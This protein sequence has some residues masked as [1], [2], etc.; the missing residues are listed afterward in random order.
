[1][2][3]DQ[4]LGGTDGLG[5]VEVAENEPVF[6]EEWEKAA[7]GMFSMAFRAGFFDVDSFLRYGIEQMYPAAYLLS[8]YYD[9]WAHT[10]AHY[11]VAKGEIDPAGSPVR[12]HPMVLWCFTCRRS[13]CRCGCVWWWSSGTGGCR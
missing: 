9:H 6:R 11:G 1:V 7:Y 2:N 3:G 10:V 8:P 4:D 12:G 5:P 13:R